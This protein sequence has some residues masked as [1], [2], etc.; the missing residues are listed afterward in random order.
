LSTASVDKMLKTVDNFIII[1]ENNQ[2]AVLFVNKI[3]FDMR[4]L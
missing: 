2:F 1:V 3:K 4:R